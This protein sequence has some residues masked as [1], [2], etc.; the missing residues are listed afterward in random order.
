MSDEVQVESQAPG[1]DA[2]GAEVPVVPPSSEA[3]VAPPVEQPVA[4]VDVEDGSSAKVSLVKIDGE[5]F[6]K[7][8]LGDKAHYIRL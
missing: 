6:A 1:A 8:V 2:V 4:S 3:S 5:E 7:V